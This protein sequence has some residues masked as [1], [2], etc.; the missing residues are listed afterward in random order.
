MFALKRIINLQK[1]IICLTG[2][3]VNKTQVSHLK[4]FLF[5]FFIWEEKKLNPVFSV[6]VMAILNETL[7]FQ[8]DYKCSSCVCMWGVEPFDVSFRCLRH[9]NARSLNHYPV[10]GYQSGMASSWHLCQPGHSTVPSKKCKLRH[11]KTHLHSNMLNLQ[12]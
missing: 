7:L 12:L 9:W 4:Y 6:K 5:L 2:Y 1:Y 11:K 3:F 10:H 8:V